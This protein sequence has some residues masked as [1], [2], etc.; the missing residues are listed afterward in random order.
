MG[1]SMGTAD[2]SCRLIEKAGDKEA[3]L[4]PLIEA[5]VQA[6]DKENEGLRLAF[7][8]DDFLETLKARTE[9]RLPVFQG[10]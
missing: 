4:K 5:V 8:P 9:K 3:D 1:K 2:K 10:R 7:E 6:L